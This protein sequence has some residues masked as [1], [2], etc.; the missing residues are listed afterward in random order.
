V[1][2]EVGEKNLAVVRGDTVKVASFGTLSKKVCASG[3][4]KDMEH[5]P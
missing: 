5:F 1:E 2:S 4:G 3:L